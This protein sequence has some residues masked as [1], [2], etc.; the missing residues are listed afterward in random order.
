M[1]RDLAS[2]YS[3]VYLSNNPGQMY[4]ALFVWRVSELEVWS[5]WGFFHPE[6]RQLLLN[7]KS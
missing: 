2:G 5:P 6:S 4:W 1:G 7:S 3:V